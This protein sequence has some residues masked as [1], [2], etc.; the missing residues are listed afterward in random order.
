MDLPGL[1]LIS[2]DALKGIN[3]DLRV[4]KRG[5]LSGFVVD[6]GAGVTHIV[7]VYESV[8]LNDSTRRLFMS[9]FLKRP[10]AEAIQITKN[11]RNVGE[12]KRLTRGDTY[13]EIKECA[14]HHRS[15]DFLRWR[16]EKVLLK[17]LPEP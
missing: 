1:N 11:G 6:S 14:S 3:D 2:D 7:S 15:A 17:Y 4:V 16:L 5:L 9:W 10:S 12:I 8:I 13:R